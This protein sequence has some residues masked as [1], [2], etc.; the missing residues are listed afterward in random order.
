MVQFRFKWVA[1][2]V[3]L[4]LFIL[5][6]TFWGVIQLRASGNQVREPLSAAM[7]A[8]GANVEEIYVN[9]WAKLP[10][11]PSKKEQDSISL[12]SMVEQA[13][14]KLEVPASEVQVSHQYTVHQEIVRGE[15]I[16]DNRH[17]VVIAQIMNPVSVGQEKEVYLVVN[18]ESRAEATSV[19][20]NLQR[21]VGEIINSFG[22]SPRINT[23]LVGWLDGKLKDE[24]WEKTLQ[25]G[26]LAIGATTI[27]TTRYADF[28]SYTGFSAAIP[29]RLQVGH[30]T[31][32]FNMAMRYS[33]YDNR[34]YVIIGSPVITSE[35]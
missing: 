15:A 27:D 23:C 1:V 30:Q 5:G 28:A 35:Y 13:M 9:G 29:E 8:T 16:S 2:I 10:P 19:I 14:Q 20:A 11:S 34:T 4:S 3:V 22:G 32:N 25:N 12:E 24:E 18:V 17:T 26:F 31:V 6:S 7:Q 33:T 21:Q